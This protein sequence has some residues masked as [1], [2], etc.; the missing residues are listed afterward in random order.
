MSRKEEILKNQA[1]QEMLDNL[2][3]SDV[4]NVL[5]LFVIAYKLNKINA[6]VNGPLELTEQVILL[7]LDA[8]KV[9]NLALDMAKIKSHERMVLKLF[10]ETIM[11]DTI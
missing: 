10:I 4:R 3:N 7:Q 11:V 8:F 9:A 1:R 5:D 6:V 2:M